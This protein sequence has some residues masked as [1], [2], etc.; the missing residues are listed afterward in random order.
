MK[1]LSKSGIYAICILLACVLLS[2]QFQQD[3]WHDEFNDAIDNQLRCNE[4]FI[5]AIHNR[6]LEKADLY[7]DSIRYYANIVDSIH[8]L[9]C[10]ENAR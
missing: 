7:L 2:C 10:A 9:M 8:C 5:N 3:K 6:D 4:P 1:K